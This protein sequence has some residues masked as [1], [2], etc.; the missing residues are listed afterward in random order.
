LVRIQRGSSFEL[1]PQR[2]PPP[3]SPFL[4]RLSFDS[5]TPPLLRVQMLAGNATLPPPLS[6]SPSGSRSS[7]TTPSSDASLELSFD[8]DFDTD[9]N[10]IR[11]SKGSTNASGEVNTPPQLSSIYRGSSESPSPAGLPA[12]VNL[13]RSSLSRSDSAPTV[14][15]VES[16]S[17]PAPT[18]ATRSF[19]R[20]TSASAL[21]PGT[22]GTLVPSRKLLSSAHRA[23]V[24]TKPPSDEKENI[25]DSSRHVPLP[26][27]GRTG[28]SLKRYASGVS[29][30]E[31]PDIEAIRNGLRRFG[32]DDGVSGDEQGKNGIPH[33]VPLT[34]SSSLSSS[35]GNRQ[36]RSASLS[37]ASSLYSL[38]AVYR[39]IS[40]DHAEHRPGRTRSTVQAGFISTT[41]QEHFKAWHRFGNCGQ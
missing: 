6:P 22:R 18:T 40:A 27:A 5:R 31:I 39:C 28:R 16:S 36:R 19:Q 11:I 34:S 3:T 26:S 37:Q 38:N 21:T 1:V 12:S 15:A 17:I 32:L 35:T 2:V 33:A 14:A 4:R 24:S 41:V 29:T 25:L 9:G 8:Y 23:T 10:F 7:S 20:V 30:S 13:R